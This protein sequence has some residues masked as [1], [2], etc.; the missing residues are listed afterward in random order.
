MY[1]Q[2]VREEGIP[3]D[4]EGDPAPP[5]Y[6]RLGLL[7]QARRYTQQLLFEGG[8]KDLILPVGDL[9]V[10]IVNHEPVYQSYLGTPLAPGE[11]GPRDDGY[12]IPPGQLCEYLFHDPFGQARVDEEKIPEATHKRIP[13]TDTG[14]PF[15]GILRRPDQSIVGDDGEKNRGILGKDDQIRFKGHGAHHQS[16]DTGTKGGEGTQVGLLNLELYGGYPQCL[17]MI[18]R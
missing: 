14:K 5:Q 16:F 4:R 10:R 9:A 6:N 2:P 12:F 3:A 11:V 15:L 7:D 18:R 13:G 17:G 1:L 8:E